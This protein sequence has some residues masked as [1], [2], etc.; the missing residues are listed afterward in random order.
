MILHYWNQMFGA[1]L[2][3]QWLKMHL[4]FQG[5]WVWSLV[6]ELRSHIVLEPLNLGAT[7]RKSVL[8]WKVLYT[9]TK[10]QCSQNKQIT[11]LKII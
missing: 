6:E 8:K 9:A 2:P 5:I 1:S 11:I 3:A 10:T 7:T 4:A